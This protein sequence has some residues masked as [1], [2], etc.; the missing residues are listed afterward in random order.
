MVLV[1]Y[2]VFAPQNLIIIITIIIVIIN[3][4]ILHTIYGHAERI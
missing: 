4:I 2:N 3:T 1:S